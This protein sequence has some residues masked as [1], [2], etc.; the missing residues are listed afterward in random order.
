MPKISVVIPLYNKRPHIKR[1]LHSVLT[2]TFQD[3]EIIVVDDGSTDGGGKIVERIS[4]SRVRLIRQENM[5]VSFARNRGIEQASSNLIAFLDADDEWRPD[6]LGTIVSL[7]RKYIEAGAYATAYEIYLPNGKREHIKYKAIPKAPWEGLLP[8]YF[9][10]GLGPN[11]L[12]TSAVAVPRDVFSRV[13]GFREGVNMGEDLEMWLRIALQYPIAF[14]T[15]TG[16]TYYQNATNRLCNTHREEDGLFY[17]KT[18]I[19]AMQRN[20]VADSLIGD[21]KEYVAFKQIVTA[22]YKIF[23]GDLRAARKLLRKCKTKRFFL[24]KAYWFLW[25]A[26]PIS[27]P[28][29][30]RKMKQAIFRNFEN[31]KT[32]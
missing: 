28:L 2:Q 13:G 6:F 3:F 10:A 23:I 1:A 29:L 9:R 4:D 20:E 11:P 31:S 8:N 26:L 18:A 30:L 21:L 19:E 5:G 15:Y 24:R 17:L 25:S 14:S 16:A 22:K 27:M 12:H 32:S 7:R